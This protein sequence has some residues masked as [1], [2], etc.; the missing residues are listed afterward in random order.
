MLIENRLKKFSDYTNNDVMDNFGNFTQL[1]RENFDES[2]NSEK[3]YFKGAYCHSMKSDSYP[4]LPHIPLDGTKK[5]YLLGNTPGQVNLWPNESW[6]EWNPVW[7]I[8]FKK[9]KKATADLIVKIEQADLSDN[10]TQHF[11]KEK[12]NLWKKISWHNRKRIQSKS[13]KQWKAWTE[14]AKYV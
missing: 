12:T 11:S 10:E 8:Q 6:P 2:I 4:R 14:R 1:Q 5:V 13:K 3:S 9:W 7:R